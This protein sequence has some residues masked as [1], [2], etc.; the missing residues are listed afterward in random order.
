MKKSR[1]P[2]QKHKVTGKDRVKGSRE[3]G[4]ESNRENKKCGRQIG[5]GKKGGLRE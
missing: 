1:E 4:R 2:Q 3:E 5:E